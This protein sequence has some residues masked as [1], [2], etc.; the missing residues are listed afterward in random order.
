[1][2]QNPP[3]AL[4]PSS[5]SSQFA[6]K[7]NADLRETQ[8]EYR[9]GAEPHNHILGNVNRA[10]HP[11]RHANYKWRPSTIPCFI[12]VCLAAILVTA[13]LVGAMVAI[14]KNARGSVKLDSSMVNRES[15]ST[16]SQT[17]ARTESRFTNPASIPWS[18]P[19]TK[20]D[21]FTADS[22][23]LSTQDGPT[24]SSKVVEIDSSSFNPSVNTTHPSPIDSS[25]STTE[26]TPSSSAT[27][28]PS[29]Y[30]SDDLSTTPTTLTNTLQSSTTTPFESAF[31]AST[32]PSELAQT[33]TQSSQFS[34]P[35]EAST[36]S[37]S[38]EEIA[39]RHPDTSVTPSNAPAPLPSGI[40][41]TLE[42]PVAGSPA[43]RRPGQGGQHSSP[44]QHVR[45]PTAHEWLGD[46]ESSAPRGPSHR[47]HGDQ[48]ERP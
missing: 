33:T 46:Q 5:W 18:T 43:A 3:N 41:H 23:Q 25:T 24:A 6:R 15:T 26:K 32:I 42:S 27:S 13:A 4:E 2:M 29:T 17:G 16:G 11:P 30:I 22:S 36:T 20:P 38:S 37:A 9:I 48:N 7:V 21:G 14:A 8:S 47:R 40:T 12:A 10:A 39:T 19:T 31:T 44:A 45:G 28:T 35:T 34:S 1:M